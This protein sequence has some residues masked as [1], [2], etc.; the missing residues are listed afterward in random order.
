MNF[1]Y[2]NTCKV[3]FSPTEADRLAKYWTNLRHFIPEEH[4]RPYEYNDPRAAQIMYDSSQALG[5]GDYVKF[6]SKLYVQ[7]ISWWSRIY[8]QGG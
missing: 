5:F 3:V 7:A 1:I 4:P 8:I 6:L 2:S